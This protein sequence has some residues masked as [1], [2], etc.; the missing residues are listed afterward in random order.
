MLL[1]LHDT[2]CHGFL[3][4]HMWARGVIRPYGISVILYQIVN[5]NGLIHSIMTSDNT[6]IHE[7]H[8]DRSMYCMYAYC[9]IY[10]K[11]LHWDQCVVRHHWQQY[12]CRKAHVDNYPL[13]EWWLA[14]TYF[15]SLFDCHPLMDFAASSMA[16]LDWLS[17][18]QTSSLSP[19]LQSQGC[20]NSRTVIGD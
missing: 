5:N 13:I 3:L 19:P 16:Y 18:L 14:R 9:E 11:R 20:L 10:K 7:K 1:H 8:S 4:L 15:T 2:L 12:T 17:R 6:Y